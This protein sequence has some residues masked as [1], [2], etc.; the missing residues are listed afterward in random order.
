M[1]VVN[2]GGQDYSIPER[3]KAKWD[4]IKDGKLSRKDDDRVYIVDGRERSGKSVFT[5]QQ[6]AYIDP[7]IIKNGKDGTI[8]PRITYNP[9]ETIKIIRETKSNDKE[10]KVIIWD[11]AFRGMSSS[12]G[13]SKVNKQIK[14]VLQEMGQNN[15]V[16]FLVS[17]TFFLLE[18]YASAV[19]SEALFH[20]VKNK[21]YPKRRMFQIFNYKKKGNLYRA[22]LRKGWNYNLQKTREKGWFFEKYPGGEELEK[23]YRKKKW[24]SLKEIDKKKEIEKEDKYIEQRNK[25]IAYLYKNQ[26]KSYRKAASWLKEAGVDINYSTVKDICGKINGKEGVVLGV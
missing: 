3:L 20:I 18:L 13:L 25:I 2:V 1:T 12:S 26:I 8:L 15:L 24:D 21:R 9:E 5:L 23:I 22:G 6:A 7:S 17:P 14:Q 16:L 11:E 4:L 19:R 10:T